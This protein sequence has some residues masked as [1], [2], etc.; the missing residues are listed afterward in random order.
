MDI[1]YLPAVAALVIVLLAALS[2]K[3]LI[4]YRKSASNEKLLLEKLRFTISAGDRKTEFFSNMAH[5]LKTPLSVI[6]AAVQL[7]ELRQKEA[8]DNASG[9]S[10]Q[11]SL[12]AIKYN[13]YRLLRITYNLLDLSKIEAGYLKL[14]PVKCDLNVLL[15]E[16]V[17]SVRP[18]AEKR[19]LN[20][21]FDKP[22]EAVLI[23]LDVE[24][25]ERIMLNLLSNAIKFTGP[26]GTVSVSYRRAGNSAFICVSDTGIGIDAGQQQHVFDRYYRAESCP[27]VK[28]EGCGIGLSLVRAFVNLH[29]GNIRIVSEKNRGSEFIVELPIEQMNCGAEEYKSVEIGDRIAE[30]VKIEF[31]TINTLSY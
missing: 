8:V 4:M 10:C 27:S 21:R 30:D 13:C 28:N 5:E 26:G 20:L 12:K 6:L 31:S 15:D 19:R 25:M 9:G 2:V 11:K 24:K 14:K 16:I 7:M 1:R 23:A 18:I 3:L 22:P 17:Q 29:S